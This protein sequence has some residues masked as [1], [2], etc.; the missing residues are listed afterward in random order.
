MENLNYSSDQFWFKFEFFGY[1]EH[2][3]KKGSKKVIVAIRVVVAT[4][5]QHS[6]NQRSSE[7]NGVVT[8]QN[9]HYENQ[10]NQEKSAEAAKKGLTNWMECAG[11]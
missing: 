2:L 3:S 5:Q 4:V 6:R 11:S 9:S 7:V 1:K 8:V 10:A